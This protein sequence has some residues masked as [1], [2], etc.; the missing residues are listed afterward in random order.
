[1]KKRIFG[2]KITTILSVIFCLIIAVIFWL[3]VK[4]SE[5]G[6]LAAFMNIAAHGG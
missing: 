6:S 2:I 1:M 3:L 4:Y 5:Q